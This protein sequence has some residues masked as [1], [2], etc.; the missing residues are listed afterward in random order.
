MKS[1]T[2]KIEIDQGKESIIITDGD[3]EKRLKG[4]MVIGAGYFTGEFYMIGAGD[5]RD[6]AYAFGEGLSRGLAHDEMIG[7]NWYSSFY[8]YL[9]YEMAKRTGVNFGKEISVEEALKMFE[10]KAKPKKSN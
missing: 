3:N 1:L 10:T 7:D 9:L 8:K 6:T 4:V 5:P 2:V